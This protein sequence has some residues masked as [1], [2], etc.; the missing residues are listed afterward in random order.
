[1]TQISCSHGLRA[2]PSDTRWALRSLPLWISLLLLLGSVG[3]GAAKAAEIQGAPSASVGPG[4]E[5]AIAD[6]DGDLHPDLASIQAGQS[7][8][9]TGTSTYW[10]QLRLSAVGLQSIRLIAPAGGLRIEARDVNGDSAVD[11]VVAT[12]W[13]SRPVAIL[14][15]DGHGGFSRVEPAAFPAAFSESTTNWRAASARSA[16]AVGVSPPSRPA[17]AVET[18]TLTLLAQ[19][20][21]SASPFTSG[22][23]LTAFL[24]SHAGRAPPSEI[25]R[26]E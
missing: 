26:Y 17:F 9:S 4:P 15:N 18:N 22:F 14:L 6:F 25:C 23:S 5:F 24:I 3:A 20:A 12:A 13:L 21:G 10:I 1:M 8:P 19:R 16:D 2:A 11:L 7:A